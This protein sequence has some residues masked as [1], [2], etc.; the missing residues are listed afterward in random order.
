MNFILC[1]RL[2]WTTTDSFAISRGEAQGFAQF[3]DELRTRVTNFL[4]TY[5]CDGEP[6]LRLVQAVQLGDDA[7]AAFNGI[8]W[9]LLAYSLALAAAWVYFNP[10]RG[11]KVVMLY[12]FL[13]VSGFILT[14][15][16][17]YHW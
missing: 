12:V 4:V 9:F 14:Y 5:Q 16:S 17:V 1:H 6:L 2:H 11:M 10:S 3:G 7:T 13:S 8:A 15:V